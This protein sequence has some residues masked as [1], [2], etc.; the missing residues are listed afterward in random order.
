VTRIVTAPRV[1]ILSGFF[2]ACLSG[3]C[4]S[5]DNTPEPAPVAD[6]APAAPATTI[7]DELSID[8]IGVY[9][10]T[11]STLVAEGELRPDT[12]INAPIIAGRPAL[13][14][15]FVKAIGRT[16]PEIQGE[17]RVKR[18]GKED[19]VLKDGG[20]RVVPELDEEMLEQTLNFNLAAE[21]MT[22][23]A[24]FSVRA[25]IKLDGEG[26]DVVKFPA[27]GTAAPFSAKTASQKLKVKFVPVSYEADEG[28][29][30]TPDLADLS[31]LK[32]TLYKMYPVASVEVSVRAP[33]KWS[34]PVKSNGPGWDELLTGIMQLRRADNVERDVYYVGVFTP[35]ASI[36]QFC[37][38]GGCILGIA[39]QADERSV[40]MRVALVLGYKSRSA[41]STLAQELAHAMGRAHAPCGSPAD[42]DPDF[43]YGSG[44]IGVWGYDLIAKKLIDPGNRYRDFMSYCGPTWVSDYTYKGLYERMATL[45]KQQD[46]IDAANGGAPAPAGSG[47]SKTEVMQSFRVASDGSI[48]EGPAL[49]VIPGTETD[50]RFG[51]TVSYEGANGQVFATAK[52]RV[53]KISGTGSRIVVAPTAPLGATR[54][55]IG[56]YGV[57]ALRTIR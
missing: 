35:K 53:I 40:N 6:P 1:M 9:Q 54:A 16:R 23:D 27:D 56:S 38:S 14:R 11:K 42:I 21:D 30:I 4:G 47:G 12:K 15:V 25:G 29:S 55:R 26:A 36:D 39:P 49:D 20:K 33:L 32:D 41:G 5:N 17:L 2:A 18:A 10:G 22:A 8:E 48:H 19:L 28:A 7:A 46:A 34:T 51:E 3:G 45:T 13:I 31:S 57:T 37:N 50:T 24:T 52:G 44:G 43:P